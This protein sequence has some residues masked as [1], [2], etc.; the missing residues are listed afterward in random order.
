M[1]YFDVHSLREMT[2]NIRRLDTHH[3]AQWPDASGT[4]KSPMI[5]GTGGGH[6]MM[7][8]RER[9]DEG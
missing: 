5:H 6:G 1:D 4:G 9:R 3:L 7:K 2:K 8:R